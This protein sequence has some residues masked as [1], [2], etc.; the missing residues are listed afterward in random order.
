MKRIFA[1]VVFA[2]VLNGSVT[3]GAQSIENATIEQEEYAVYSATIP[4]YAYEE[5]GTIVIANPTSNSAEPIKLKDLQ[6]F[7][8]APAPVLSQKTLDD[9]FQRNKSNR[10]LTPKLEMNRKYVLADFR[11]IKKLASDFS[12]KDQ[13]WK[14]FFKEYPASH[15]FVN[16][17]RAGFNR[18]MDQALVYVGWNCP[19]LCGHWS[20]ILL[21]K[22]DGAWKVVAEANRM[23]S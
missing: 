16:L 17:S 10:W 22:K 9:F 12:A 11:E 14:A 8:F 3:A 18:Q 13:E 2:L 7:V 21:S 6:F 15:G 23:V 1:S 20:F 19:G 5:T 4:G